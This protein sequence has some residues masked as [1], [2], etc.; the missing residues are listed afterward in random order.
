[1]LNPSPET[2]NLLDAYSTIHSKVPQ[3]GLEKKDVYFLSTG[4]ENNS[5]YTQ[6]TFSNISMLWSNYVN[7]H[8][9]CLWKAVT[10][11]YNN[12]FKYLLGK[13]RIPT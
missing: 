1:M 11:L 2:K 10:V 5:L 3:G 13:Y 12:L 8:S 6:I 7:K 4:P 9:T